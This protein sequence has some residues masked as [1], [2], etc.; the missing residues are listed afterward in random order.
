MDNRNLSIYK[1][2]YDTKGVV[3]PIEHVINRIKSGDR[4]LEKKTQDLNTWYNSNTVK[5][6]ARKEELPA[7]TWSGEFPPVYG[8]R[9]GKHLVA[10]SGLIVLDVDNDIDM[11]SVLADFAQNPHIFFAFISPSGKGI[12]PVIPVSPIPQNAKEHAH[13]FDAV[14]DVFFEYA[15]QDPE[16]LKKQRD[17]NRLCFL[18]HD[19]QPI[20]N[21][22][23]I[24]IEWEIDE[25]EEQRSRESENASTEVSYGDVTIEQA[26]HVLSFVPRDLP[27]SE[28]RNIGMGIKAAGLP[29]SV[30][31]EWSNNQRLNSS[32]VWVSEDCLSHW[33][34]YNSQGITWGSVVHV[35]KQNGYV[36]PA[37]RKPVKLQNVKPYEKVIETLAT[38][39]AFLKG[40]F[41]EG[42]QFFAIRTDT[43]T[44]KT[45]N[46]I[47]YAITRDVAIPTQSG[48]LRDEI[49]SR[50][51][52]KEI[53]AWGYRGIR[54][55][56]EADGYMPCIQS[57][58]FDL[59]RQKGFNPY[60]WICE[61]CPAQHECRERGYLSQ[62]DRAKASQ[63][64]AIPFPTAFLDGRLRNWAKMY[65]PRE[66]LIL[67][68]DLPLTSL[69]IEYKLTADRLR[70]ILKDWHGTV[71]TEWAEILLSCFISRDWE[72]MKRASEMLSATQYNTVVQ[73]F[74]R[75]KLP[76]TGAI[77]EAD[78]L[79]RSN[80]VDYSTTEAIAQLPTVDSEKFDT[81][82]MLELFWERY[83][84]IE[85]APF[86]YDT[87]TETFTFTFL[88]KP[89][90]SKKIRVG[91]AGATMQK[92]LMLRIFPDIEFFDANTTEWEKGRT[93]LPAADKPK[94]TRYRAERRRKIPTQ[95]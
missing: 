83:P 24:P 6:Q 60:K 45:E 4:G 74:T 94:P 25:A 51:S 85:D 61:S 77:V 28:W 35:A 16:H 53:F 18:A 89:Y 55:T 39:R 1:G 78:T 52:G 21:P 47:T 7:V 75:C 68:D 17:P 32:G 33:G 91:F 42:S 76:E 38:A 15:D 22:Q 66:G 11:G 44:G 67:H 65:L 49:V 54:E 73:A 56:E 26:K 80:L 59:F 92:D 14:L 31:S 48:D 10:H 37:H 2:I 84:R 19:P 72:K 63:L 50:A 34:R 36:T 46:A 82:T 93:P 71:A 12:K 9:L 20:Y 41:E 79:I 57:E 90:R 43:G 5:Y 8:H 23:A 29:V 58:R 81:A 3:Y 64:L 86:F 95:R 30:F 13:A 70:R 69:F 87:A 40:I 27:Y 88:P 62:P